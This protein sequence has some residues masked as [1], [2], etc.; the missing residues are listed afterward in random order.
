MQDAGSEE[1]KEGEGEGRG[2]GVVP[3]NTRRVWGKML[4]L[5]AEKEMRGS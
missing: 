1:G 5:R 4:C 3:N 2:G